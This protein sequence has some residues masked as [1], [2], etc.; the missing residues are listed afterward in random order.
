[1][2]KRMMLR[3]AWQGNQKAR[4]CLHTSPILPH[5]VLHYTRSS[6]VSRDTL[7]YSGMSPKPEHHNAQYPRIPSITYLGMSLDGSWLFMNNTKHPRIPSIIPGCPQK[8]CLITPILEYL[9]SRD[10]QYHPG[11]PPDG[12]S[13]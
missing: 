11:I 13:A 1:M 7:H 2:M 10:T 12:M 4:T 8:V 6:P 3:A 5:A 9:V